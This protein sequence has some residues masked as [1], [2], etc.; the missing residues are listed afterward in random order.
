MT[1]G[2]L[3]HERW[4]L[5]EPLLDDALELEPE[6]RSAFL[7]DVCRD[8]AELRTELCNLLAAC[9]KGDT[10]LADPAAVAY[11]PLLAEL[12]PPIPSP[13]SGRYHIVREIGRGGMGTVYLANDAKH[14]RQ[15][16]VKALHA[17]VARLIGSERFEREIEIAASLSHPHILPLHDSGEVKSEHEGEPSFLYFITPFA[18]G[19]TLRDRLLREIRLA[20]DEAVR[21]GKEIAQA[22]DYAH[23]RGVVHLDIKP[24]NILLHEGHAVIADFGIARAISKAGDGSS[25]IPADAGEN[26]MPMLGTP[27]YMSPE[28]AL[29][30][31]DVDGRSDVYS[32]GCVLFEMLTG[33]QPF[34]RRTVQDVVAGARTTGGPDPGALCR[35]VSRE[36]ATVVLR[37]MSPS[38]EERYSTAG[39]LALALDDARAGT[40]PWWRRTSVAV[41]SGVAVVV[42]SF[43]VWESQQTAAYDPNLVAVAPFDVAA[44]ALLL[45]KEGLVDVMSRSLDGA[46]AI[47]AVPASVVVHRWRG[48]ADSASARALGRATGA[49]LVVYGGLLAAGD[50]VRATVSLLDVRTGRTVSEFERRDV[51]ARMDRLSDSLTLGVLRELGRSRRIDMA[52]ATSSP[53]NSLAALKTYL[54]GE[55]YYR[56]AAWD[57]AQARFEEA[58]A[59]DTTFAM[60][61]H[62]LAAVRRWRDAHDP[63]DSVAYEL[64]RLPSHYLRGL[65]PRERL[66]ATID[67]LTAE[68]YFARRRALRDGNF[69]SEEAVFDSLCAALI[70]AQRRYPND[71]ELAFLH[72]EARAEYD[73]EVVVG[74]VDDRGTLARYDHAISLDSTFAPAYVRPINFAAYL[75]GAPSARRYINAYLALAP[76]GARSQLIRLE[77][78]LLD[79]ARAAAL[80]ATRLVDTLPPDALCAAVGLLRHIP[81]SA[82]TV[83]RIAR[84]YL[85]QPQNDS[86]ARRTP[87]GCVEEQLLKGL[88]FRGH[89]RDASRLTSLDPYGMRTLVTYD[90]A[91]FNAVPRDSSRAEFNRI[92]AL[93]PGTRMPRLYAW[94]ASDGDTAAIRTYIDS[95]WAEGDRIRTPSADAMIRAN[96]VSGRGYLALAKRD[97]A[98]ALRVLAG[99]KD[100]LSECWSDNR[101]TIVR[102]L[103]AAG[104]YREAAHRLERRWPGTTSCSNGIDDVLWTMERA[105]VLDRLGQ[106]NGAAANYAFVM[107]AWRTADPELQPYVREASAA[108]RRLRREGAKVMAD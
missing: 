15:V 8:D 53:T 64:M 9:D 102:L 101:V 34:A 42:A 50:S 33:D 61:Y 10:I 14:G 70:D 106:R 23:R 79:P 58:L 96:I 85:A 87:H 92:L 98:T 91:R 44:P 73:R 103:V 43:A 49:R 31:P 55:Q 51:S 83:V 108:L 93:A 89:L 16:A 22:L 45:W 60:A 19:E 59:L 81:D 100:T 66:L 46:G 20:P 76:A 18:A 13:I 35:N 7:D 72:A 27:S 47:R 107:A 3:S 11:A 62:R 56:A 67:S 5:L 88:E 99:T 77:G 37:A 32:L 6:R 90:L 82:E 95:F 78:D 39:E 25:V 41:A 94:W 74:E 38:R 63:P 57:S 36:L 17:E 40:P 26:A 2:S 69:A 29:G 28:Q 86:L 71:A 1:F 75:D 104:R 80:D 12:T 65:G 30:L 54:Q 52:H 84:A 105:R 24:G 21:L 48:R 97:S 68:T 4:K